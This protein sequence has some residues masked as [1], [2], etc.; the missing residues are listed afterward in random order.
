MNMFLDKDT[1]S[2]EKYDKNETTSIETIVT[3]TS[4]DLK[5]NNLKCRMDHC[6][7]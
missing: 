1:S 4:P 7:L 2:F 6:I 5:V 3:Y